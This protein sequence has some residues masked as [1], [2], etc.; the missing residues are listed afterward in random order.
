[1]SQDWTSWG[2]ILA[3][4]S[5]L[6]MGG[7][8]SFKIAS[9]HVFSG[10]YALAQI[11]PD[12]TLGTEN[13]TVT[14]A[15]TVDQI[16]GGAT[17]GANLFHSFEEF[18]VGDRRAAYFTNPPG[19]ENI[20]SRVTGT[21]PSNIEGTLG[22][23]GNANLFLINPNGI[24]FGANARLDVRGSFVGTT[25]NAIAFGDQGFFSASEPNVPLLLTV[26][27]SAFFFNQIAAQPM[28]SIENQGTLA[29][30]DN[31]SLLLVGGN[32]SPS[33][34][35][36]GG[37]LIDGGTLQAPGGR[38]ELG[39][40]TGT[41]TVGLNV[42]GN[43]LS[44]S[45][46]S[47]VE[48]VD[49]SLTNRAE[50]NVLAG[51][52]GSIAV[53]A[54]NLDILGGSRFLAGIGEALGTVG[55]QAGDITLNATG[56]ITLGQSDWIFS[57]R[58]ENRVN[59]KATGNT[60]DINIQARSLSM[61]DN[62]SISTNH[63]GLGGN[64][65]SI[66]VQ[67]EDAVSLSDNSYM[68]SSSTGSVPKVGNSGN[69]QIEA[70]SLSMESARL[71]V[72]NFRSRSRDDV[73]FG[74]GNTGNISIQVEDTV[75]LKDSLIDS[76]LGIFVIGNGG[77]IQIK[78]GALTMIDEGRLSTRLNGKG[79]GGS[80]SIEVEDVVS[81]TTSTISSGVGFTSLNLRGEGNGGNIQIEAGS[82]S[83]LADAYISAST[84]G[85]GNAGNIFVQVEDDISLSNRS[86]ITSGV[87]PRGEGEGGDIQIDAR[88]LFLTGDAVLT[89]ST[90]GK[91]NAGNIQIDASD[92]VSISGARLGS[93]PS[94][95]S[96]LFTTTENIAIGQGGDISVTTD[97]LTVSDRARLNARTNN[98]FRSGNITLNVN[99]L[100]V[101]SGGQLVTTTF[102]SGE[103][104]NITVN[105][106]ESI[107][108]SGGDST[109]LNQ[110]SQFHPAT[111]VSG[112]FSNT[113]PDSTGNGGTVEVNTTYLT[114]SDGAE[115]SVGSE[116]A[117]DAGNLGVTSRHLL[118]DSRGVLR[119]TTSSG[120]GGNIE[121]QEQDLILMRR[122]SEIS[123]E[124]RGSGNGGDITIDADFIV[125]VPL[126]DSD[127]VA[128]A[129]EGNGGNIRITTQGIYG[130]E[131][132]PRRTPQSDITASS[133]FGVDG[134]VE[135]NTPDIDPTR[136]LA[137]LPAEPVNPE[138]A[139]SCQPG[140]AET[141]S[142]FVVTGRG[143]LP[144]NPREAL[145]SDAVEVD[146]VTLN[147]FEENRSRPTVSTNP[148][149][150]TLVPIVEAQGWV[151]NAKGE[152]LLTATAP[153]VTP[154]SSWRP[155]TGCGMS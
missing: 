56:A 36:T 100:E 88:S 90:D 86:Y 118:L 27:P 48:R 62:A 124:A 115:V 143:G 74:R 8:I 130:L 13:S 129:F 109:Y 71:S 122:N 133:D 28:H 94:S 2:A 128:D 23:L 152:V 120:E 61:S 20:L 97:T 66:S 78:A 51:G 19:I 155:L 29:V 37:I 12:A 138:V 55:T 32:V 40:V 54:R 16:N 102:S 134:V 21:N 83:M 110:P 104:G 1:M 89:T 117:G 112:L 87:N 42:D 79:N 150:S 98:A 63:F 91:G 95:Y 140:G 46:P 30:P 38:V 39:G 3:L 60:G 127:I 106:A 6:A 52:E 9:L 18:N 44:L 77:D 67:V 144:P 135:I 105:A 4:V 31:R 69:I 101:T 65:G 57:S 142:E 15:G 132:R 136:G 153:N 125:A 96:G 93:S 84:S 141:N 85:W 59:F 70:R 137:T 82:L 49:V 131:Y 119:A 50:V 92:S 76:I 43:N 53:N 111:P 113:N 26:N 68:D 103:A 5:R 121:L 148:T 108:L 33:T 35:S 58:V 17:R 154:H 72:G 10:N 123:T 64:A 126:E 146:L 47:C 116:G 99:S 22:V 149:R 147:P 151:I 145:S 41:G 25:A 107:T 114:I 24:I 11:T 80:I 75:F 139:Q 34:A 7:A 45:I 14:S 73:G 81:L